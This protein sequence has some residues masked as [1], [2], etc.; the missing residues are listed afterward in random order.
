ML[1]F[2]IDYFMMPQTH[3]IMRWYGYDVVDV[4]ATYAYMQ[5]MRLG[6]ALLLAVVGSSRNNLIFKVSKW[7]EM[8][9]K[10]TALIAARYCYSNVLFVDARC[11]LPRRKDLRSFAA[12]RANEQ[13]LLGL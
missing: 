9:I 8:Q 12:Q 13:Q 3:N 5:L 2:N 7:S 11:W 4:Y 10:L 6:S 1:T